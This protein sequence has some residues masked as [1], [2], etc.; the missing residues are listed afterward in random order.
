MPVGRHGHAVVRGCN[1]AV[2]TI[3]TDSPA[4]AQC[5]YV[6]GGSTTAAAG[7]ATNLLHA[8]NPITDSWNT[9]L[10]S[11]PT[12]RIDLAAATGRNGRIYAMGGFAGSQETKRVESFNPTTGLWSLEPDMPSGRSQLAAVGLGKRVWALGGYDKP[13]GVNNQNWNEGFGP[14]PY[15]NGCSGIVPGGL[16]KF[17]IKGTLVA[18]SISTGGT[19]TYKV[20]GPKETAGSL[21][22]GLGS[23]TAVDSG[24]VIGDDVLP[25]EFDL[26]TNFTL[27]NPGSPVLKG[28]L[29]FL[30]DQAEGSFHLTIP[31]GALSGSIV[32]TEVFH[33][34]VALDPATGL[35]VGTSDSAALTFEE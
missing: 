18:I 29:G 13:P 17:V 19:S 9:A 33:A 3:P 5:L 26:Y 35:V 34:I 10:P 21:F 15:N 22:L 8:Y 7:F 23:L 1:D 20:T 28:S 31:A 14:L 25:L 27:L 4:P 24:I 6:I 32:G 11:M 30:N 16:P 2:C 12:G